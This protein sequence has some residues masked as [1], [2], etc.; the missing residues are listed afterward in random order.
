M[1]AS[2]SDGSRLVY[3]QRGP[4]LEEIRLR[5]M[6]S[7][8]E[9]ALSIGFA[10]PKISP[11]GTKVAYVTGA[12]GPLFLMDSAGGEAAKLL[13]RVGGVTIFGWSADGKQI[14]YWDG[15]PVRFSVFNLETRQTSELISHPTYTIHGAELSRD[16]KWVAFHLPRAGSEPVKIAPVRDG[17]AAG[18]AEWITVTAATGFNRRP[19]WSPNG[20]LLYFLSTRDNYPCIWAQPLDPATKQPRGEPMAIS[21]FHETRRSVNILSTNLFGPAVG[22]GRVVFALA[23]QTGNIWVAEPAAPER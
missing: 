23:E 3:L 21:H 20:N 10:R 19:W 15:T 14:V 18:E 9:L 4:S 16:G 7:G 6:R 8:S 13:D 1:P 22:G 11:D 5:D 17:K 12:S 2:S